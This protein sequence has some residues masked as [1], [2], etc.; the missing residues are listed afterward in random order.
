MPQTR[1]FPIK[2]TDPERDDLGRLAA[3]TGRSRPNVIRTLL[4]LALNDPEVTRKL[5]EMPPSTTEW[6]SRERL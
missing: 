1:I 6:F 2:L 4:R 3:M 5:G